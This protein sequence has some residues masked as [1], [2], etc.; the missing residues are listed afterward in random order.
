MAF[1]PT[2]TDSPVGPAIIPTGVG[3]KGAVQVMQQGAEGRQAGY[4]ILQT[5]HGMEPDKDVKAEEA[6][7]IPGIETLGKALDP[8][9]LPRR[10]VMQILAG[11]GMALPNPDTKVGEVL[12][13]ITGWWSA[14]GV[15]FYSGAAPLPEDWGLPADIA[16]SISQVGPAQMAAMSIV[17][18]IRD[19]EGRAERESITGEAGRRLYGALATGK[20]WERGLQHRGEFSYFGVKPPDIDGRELVDSTITK[21]EARTAALLAPDP[22]NRFILGK[23]MGTEGGRMAAG[24][25][26]DMTNPADPLWFLGTSRGIKQL[27]V[28]DRAYVVQPRATRA[29]AAV[30]RVTK[31]EADDVAREAIQAV[32]AGDTTATAQKWVNAATELAAESAE[33]TTQARTASRLAADGAQAL[34]AVQKAQADAATKIADL[35]ARFADP[36]EDQAAIKILLQAARDEQTQAALVASLVRNDKGRAAAHFAR[37]AGARA[38]AARSTAAHADDAVWAATEM[39]RAPKNLVQKAGTLAMHNPLAPSTPTRFLIPFMPNPIF[40][41]AYYAGK[42]IKPYTYR[43]LS[44][45]VEHLG[46]DPAVNLLALSR[47][48]RLAWSVYKIAPAE[49]ARKLLSLPGIAWER[50]A[51]HLGDGATQLS[52]LAPG[53]APVTEEGMLPGIEVAMGYRSL[54]RVP[55]QLWDAFLN[56][57]SK[58]L[59]GIAGMQYQLNWYAKR[60]Y[61]EA[62]TLYQIM[63][64]ADPKLDKDADDIIGMA[65]RAIERGEGELARRPELQPMI[66]N[67]QAMSD[68]LQKS[69]GMAKDEINQAIQNLARFVKE[70]PHKFEDGIETLRSMSPIF[71]KELA[72]AS[73]YR[74]TFNR[75]LIGMRA[76]HQAIL[77]LLDTADLNLMAKR[78]ADYAQSHIQTKAMEAARVAGSTAEDIAKAGGTAASTYTLRNQAALTQIIKDALGPSADVLWPRVRAL[79]AKQFG[80]AEPAVASRLYHMIL[81]ETDALAGAD[82]NSVK[83]AVERLAEETRRDLEHIDNFLTKPETLGAEKHAI[84]GM[85]AKQTG[86]ALARTTEA[87]DTDRSVWE[88]FLAWT[89]NPKDDHARSIV[90]DYV[91]RTFKGSDPDGFMTKPEASAL[92]NRS[93]SNMQTVRATLQA[94]QTELAA[95]APHLEG[96]VTRTGAAPAALERSR[97]TAA[98]LRR[99]SADAA[100]AI[101]DPGLGGHVGVTGGLIAHALET[102]PTGKTPAAAIAELREGLLDALSKHVA[103]IDEYVN[104]DLNKLIP[105]MPLPEGFKVTDP[106][107]QGLLPQGIDP[108]PAYRFLDD[109][110]AQILHV[111]NGLTGRMDEADR[112]TLALM[113]TREGPVLPQDLAGFQRLRQLYPHLVGQ[114]YG[115]LDPAIVPMVDAFKAL[116]KRYED[117][118]A[119]QGREF[120]ASPSRMLRE[121]G[122]A[123]YF[124]HIETPSALQASEKAR[125]FRDVQAGTRGMG[126]AL[127]A[128]LSSDTGAGKLRSIRGALDEINASE[129]SG[130]F[131]LSVDIHDVLG[132]YGAANRGLAAQDMLLAFLRSGIIRAVTDADARDFTDPEQWVH[133]VQAFQSLRET[134]QRLN[135]SPAQVL[136][137][138]KTLDATMQAVQKMLGYDTPDHAYAL[139]NGVFDV[140]GQSGHIP[141]GTVLGQMTP[142]DPTKLGSAGRARIET[143]L[144]ADPNTLDHEVGHLV[145]V[146]LPEDH[147]VKQALRLVY[148]VDPADPGAFLKEEEWAN[149]YAAWVKWA[150]DQVA[151]PKKPCPAELRGMVSGA[152]SFME[153]IRETVARV[154]SESV[155]GAERGAGPAE[156]GWTRPAGV[157]RPLAAGAPAAGLQTPE[158]TQAILAPMFQGAKPLPPIP[159]GMKK[160][161]W[162]RTHDLVPL[163]Q[164]PNVKT[165]MDL[166]MSGSLAD[167]QGAGVNPQ[168]VLDARVAIQAARGQALT[169]GTDAPAITFANWLHNVPALR[170]QMNVEDA[171]LYIR[172][173][174][175]EA[176]EELY[177]PLS[178]WRAFKAS[179]MAKTP[180]LSDEAADA[181]AW[182]RTAAEM[183]RVLGGPMD[184]PRVSGKDLSG[185]F[186]EQGSV[187]DMYIPAGLYQALH[188]TFTGEI[189]SPK[190]AAVKRGL[191]ALNNFWKERLTIIMTAF[192][193]RNVWNMASVVTDV[194]LDGALSFTNNRETARIL[195]AASLKQRF[196]TLAHASAEMVAP[197]KMNEPLG[198]FLERR[199]MYARARDIL[200]DPQKWNL[201]GMDLGDGVPR[202]LD[203]IVED[204]E[205]SGVL[206]GAYSAMRDMATWEDDMSSLMWKRSFG[207]NVRRIASAAEDLAIQ[208]VAAAGGAFGTVVPK[209]VGRV[210]SYMVEN[211]SRVLDFTANM[212]KNGDWANAVRRVNTH[213]FNYDDLTQFQKT[214]VRTV[215][216]FFTWTFKNMLLH[217]QVIRERPWIYKLYAD[218]IL[219]GPE[220]TEAFNE[221]DQYTPSG[222]W[223]PERLESEPRYRRGLI[224]IPAPG[225]PGAYLEGLGSPVEAAIQ[226][227]SIPSE[228]IR[229]LAA[230]DPKAAFKSL[231]I[232]HFAIRSMLESA[233]GYSF[234]YGKPLDEIN[235]PQNAAVLVSNLQKY[236]DSPVVGP[237]AVR[238]AAMLRHLFGLTAVAAKDAQGQP[239]TRYTV[240]APHITHA[241]A[242]MPWRQVLSALV[243][244]DPAMHR[245]VTETDIGVPTTVAPTDPWFKTWMWMDKLF[246]TNLTQD[247]PGADRARLERER[248]D[249]V[250]RDLEM[251]G[252]ARS[253]ETT[254]PTR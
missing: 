63:K 223:D 241:L 60:A 195:W 47:G 49:A 1:K 32:Q 166:L 231:A 13:D 8:L 178:R 197:R 113:M 58:Y 14:H 95:L 67:L 132:H 129:G 244:S 214:W 50:I 72:G 46:P 206:T 134:A 9:N 25:I 28:G 156:L 225:V 41:G 234:F 89:A 76:E 215:I 97:L 80:V 232:T 224:R 20:L 130:A 122:V 81:G 176:G 98:M 216:P 187:Y 104:D 242:S 167:W 31:Q 12:G 121:W 136:L 125:N 115:D 65:V 120:V 38:S 188:D 92:M 109:V 102:P 222:T 105:R 191:D 88:S 153:T 34:A 40:T 168:A 87:L 171:L 170:Q 142:P 245:P 77:G 74:D 164:R 94:R 7:A 207:S 227:Y 165:P 21:D 181:Y 55:K 144:H 148:G 209:P 151:D 152:K 84:M 3:N 150:A 163:F 149:D 133:R 201:A 183:N 228:M 204:L 193:L 70:D 200:G 11:A 162:A 179:A 254:T 218:A 145:S 127:D 135:S 118:Y 158:A 217:A 33:H 123:G 253:W 240:G 96:L 27:R 26:A 175:L 79:L 177:Q 140:A 237:T 235:S 23:V 59:S 238:L 61:G 119:E 75:A 90:Q 17:E 247:S 160:A 53:V 252:A 139:F 194:G 110:E 137:A 45:V 91:M 180:N 99:L 249:A 190:V 226:M 64:K 83:L 159:Y 221:G 212:K 138:E 18:H 37:I 202:S 52:V 211:H 42:G 186:H 10:G 128:R 35:M 146:L 73:G 4:D 248:I 205:S 229:G 169:K 230:G 219:Q 182:D 78:M 126:A 82:A 155:T 48:Q 62:A 103:N 56:A 36:A 93:R 213:L 147:P 192:P 243:A 69:N 6:Y 111:F 2:Y 124:P 29:A 185:Y 112:L 100:S 86:E 233:M 71:D 203:S 117:L 251:N 30:A 250:E 199:A 198:A 246:Y 161:E 39:A 239:T 174:N 15:P 220:V 173:K 24:L 108:Q 43:T 107:L 157:P 208:G 68:L 101:P 116:I 236:K 5:T 184:V 106:A 85:L 57:R 172:G 44:T 54:A 16:N 154:R 141:G 114:R 196:G 51:A 19:P 143:F 66:D 22:V 210:L 189:R 131:K